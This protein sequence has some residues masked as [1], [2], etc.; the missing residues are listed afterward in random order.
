MW[1]CMLTPTVDD[2]LSPGSVK[3]HPR[4]TAMIDEG[5]ERS[6]STR[7]VMAFVFVIHSQDRSAVCIRC[8]PEPE[9][10]G[11]EHTQTGQQQH[12]GLAYLC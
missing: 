1:W 5:A 9:L 2:M 11:E 6:L 8:Q 12:E 3:T 4:A 7:K 10:S